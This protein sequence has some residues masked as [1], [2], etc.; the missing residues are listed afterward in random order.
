DAATKAGI[1]DTFTE[2]AIDRFNLPRLLLLDIDG[3]VVW[4]GD[5]GFT[6][7]APWAAGQETFLDVPLTDLIEKRKLKE[8]IGWTKQWNERAVPALAAGDVTTALP[9]LRQSKGFQKGLTATV[10]DARTKLDT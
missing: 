2:Y 4:E 3:K 5:P 6:S 10:D 1:G 9:I 8:L 7:G